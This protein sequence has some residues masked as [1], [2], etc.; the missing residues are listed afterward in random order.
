MLHCKEIRTC[1]FS[2]SHLGLPGLDWQGVGVF[3]QAP[4][5]WLAENITLV[6]EEDVA[7]KIVKVNDLLVLMAKELLLAN[8]I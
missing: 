3:R 4:G 2:T 7:G 5:Q 6:R 8:K 1:P